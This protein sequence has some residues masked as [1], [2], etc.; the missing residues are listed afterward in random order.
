MEENFHWQQG[1]H[2]TGILV[3]QKYPLIEFPSLGFP[4]CDFVSSLMP[5]HQTSIREETRNWL[6]TCWEGLHYFSEDSK[7]GTKLEEWGGGAREDVSEELGWR[8]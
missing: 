3:S 6:F 5:Y 2:G 8:R 1:N 4:D 7:G